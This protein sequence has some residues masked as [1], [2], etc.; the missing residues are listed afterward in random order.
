MANILVIFKTALPD[1][2][3]GTLYQNEPGDFGVRGEQVQHVL[4]ANALV[5]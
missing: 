4:N 2:L 3:I 1:T 5:Y